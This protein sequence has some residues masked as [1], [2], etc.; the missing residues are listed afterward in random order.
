M[1]VGEA[2]PAATVVLLRD[3]PGGVE[4]LMLRKNRGQAF[5]GMWVF[6]GGKVEDADGD[7]DRDGEAVVARRAA[8]REA[9]EE[10]GVVL[11]ADALV[12]FAHWVP[13]DEA[14]KR[15][16]TWFFVAEWAGDDVA[17]D[18]HEIVDHRWVTPSAAIVDQ[19]P[20]APPTIVTLHE[21]DAARSFA[22]T[23]RDVLPRYATRHVLSNGT[24][25]M[26]WDGDVAYDSLEPDAPGPRHRLWYPSDG[27]WRY[28]RSGHGESASRPG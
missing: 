4:V 5:G 14:P 10:T 23:R 7:V 25:V 21:L 6:P 2:I 17:I 11:E 28:E 8:V 26:L 24:P 18:G 19:L 27:P 12:P 15:F 13:P 16:S 20:M 1:Q 3:G 9:A 22:A